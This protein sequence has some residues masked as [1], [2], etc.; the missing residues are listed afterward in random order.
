MKKLIIMFILIFNPF[1]IGFESASGPIDMT[2]EVQSISMISTVLCYGT[3]TN[4]EE[5][6]LVISNKDIQNN[7]IL[8]QWDPYYYINIDGIPTPLPDNYTWNPEPQC[9]MSYTEQILADNG[10]TEFNGVQSVDTANK[11]ANQNTFASTEQFDY[12]ASDT[13][14][15]RITF[16]EDLLLDGASQGSNALDRMLCPFATGDKGFIPAY[17]NVV[18]MGGSFTGTDVSAVTGANERHISKAADIPVTVNYNIALAGQGSTA[19]WINA[20]LMEGRTPD[21][22][23][24]VINKGIYEPGFINWDWNNGIG[25]FR[26]SP[27]NSF[28]LGNEYL[29]K[30]KCSASGKIL[31]FSKSIQVKDT[32]EDL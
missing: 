5:T 10:Y 30:E 16:S 1:L 14:M 9:V 23:G 15:G 29:Y 20:H 27:D 25:D 4:T 2:N 28:M 13:A 8:D 3:V 19:A 7:P 21:V 31:L 6:A 32:P 18:E 26:V 12:I 11:V 17:C 22:F 24:A